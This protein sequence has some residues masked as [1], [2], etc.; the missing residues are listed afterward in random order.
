[1]APESSINIAPDTENVAKA[2][3][4]KPASPVLFCFVAAIF[5]TGVVSLCYFFF[6]ESV[7]SVYLLKTKNPKLYWTN[8]INKLKEDRKSY[9]VFL[10]V[11]LIE[12]KK[13]ADHLS[14]GRGQ[15][16]YCVGSQQLR[17]ARSPKYVQTYH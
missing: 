14:N 8:Q 4:I 10:T 16:D 17:T 9:K 15:G 3:E 11:E 2:E 5:W 12:L 7:S 1:M 6:W 13:N